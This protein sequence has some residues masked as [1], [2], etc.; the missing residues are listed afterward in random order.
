MDQLTLGQRLALKACI[1]A[2]PEALRDEAD[3]VFYAI[4]DAIDAHLEGVRKQFEDRIIDNVQRGAV[5]EDITV[6]VRA[7]SVLD[8]AKGRALSKK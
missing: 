1:A 2:G 8:F 7:R 5:D 6:T 3:E 4:A